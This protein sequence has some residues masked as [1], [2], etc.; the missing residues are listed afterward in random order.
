ME[1]LLR[2][3]AFLKRD[4]WLNT[5]LLGTIII[6][7]RQWKSLQDKNRLVG[8]IVILYAFIHLLCTHLSMYNL[9]STWIYNLVFG[10]YSLLI[11]KTFKVPYQKSWPPKLIKGSYY[12]ILILHV[13]NC[14]YI[15]GF[16]YLATITI[17]LFQI[18]NMVMAYLYLQHRL[19][20]YDDPFLGHI[21]NWFAV[22]VIIDNVVSIPTVAL[23]SEQMVEL[24][25]Y[26]RFSILHSTH[27]VIYGMWYLITA[28]GI[29]WNTTSLSSRFS[30]SSS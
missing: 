29:I 8:F 3:I 25:G 14:F 2:E 28:A 30:S 24:V 22:A 6:V 11:W 20:Q 5:I 17:V 4:L 21:R 18:F 1:I 16:T 13:L 15:Q 26:D 27:N 12:L 23:L 7:I 19:E 9:Y 10:L